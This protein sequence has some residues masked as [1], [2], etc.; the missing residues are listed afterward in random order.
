MAFKSLER[1]TN[2]CG[3]AHAAD[4][5]GSDPAA[6]DAS[7]L[8]RDSPRRQLTY[9]ADGKGTLGREG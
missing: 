2:E 8:G 7:E 1:H 9:L 4:D 6:L 5:K 3:C